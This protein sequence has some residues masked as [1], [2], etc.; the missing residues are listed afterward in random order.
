MYGDCL[1]PLERKRCKQ[2]YKCES[3]LEAAGYR[4]IA[5]YLLSSVKKGVPCT[6]ATDATI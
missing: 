4:G 6:R 5:E 1:T 2:L 3:I